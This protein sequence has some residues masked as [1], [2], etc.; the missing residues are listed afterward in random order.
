M[1]VHETAIVD[2]GATVGKGTKI[3]HWTHVREHATIGENCVL[4]QNVYVGPSVTIGNGC[5][6][7]NNVSVYQNVVL[8]DDVFCGP[9]AVFTNVKFPRA[10]VSRH[11]EF[12]ETRV[13][14]GATIGANATILCGNEI[15]EWAFVGAGSVVVRSVAPYALV[16]GNPA[17]QVGWMCRCGE[18]LQEKKP[19]R[20]ERCGSRYLHQIDYLTLIEDDDEGP[21]S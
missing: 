1:S 4:G 15:G 19:I 13:R 17:R 21:V 3:W 18:R 9:S 8:E 16:V 10:H 2:P 20:C 5:R 14:R 11:H 7:Q 6:I 12:E